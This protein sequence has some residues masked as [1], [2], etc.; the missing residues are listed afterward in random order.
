MRYS[1]DQI[2]RVIRRRCSSLPTQRFQQKGAEFSPHK[3]NK[4]EKNK[5]RQ[6]SGKEEIAGFLFSS[7]PNGISGD[8][9]EV[10]LGI[11]HEL[12]TAQNA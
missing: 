3:Q 9:F 5:Y 4:V 6:Y 7:H 10:W 2:F 12:I 11:G 8:K 1:Q